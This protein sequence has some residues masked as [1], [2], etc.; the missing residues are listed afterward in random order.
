MSDPAFTTTVEY[1]SPAY[2]ESGGAGGFGSE[3]M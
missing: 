3:Y 1:A 2:L